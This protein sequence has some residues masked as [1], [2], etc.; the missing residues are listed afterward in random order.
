MDGEECRRVFR[1]QKQD[2]LRQL[3]FQVSH[4]IGLKTY[5]ENDCWEAAE[6]IWIGLTWRIDFCIF[7][8]KLRSLYGTK[9]FQQLAD[10]RPQYNANAMTFQQ[11]QAQAH[12]DTGTLCLPCPSAADRVVQFFQKT[13]KES[14]AERNFSHYEEENRRWFYLWEL[15]LYRKINI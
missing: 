1:D 5:P 7:T 8:W 2:K 15:P 9:S 12:R 3:V 11:A 6:E 4:F 13:G 14:S 10:T